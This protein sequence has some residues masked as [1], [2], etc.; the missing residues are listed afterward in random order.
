MYKLYTE[1]NILIA[2]KI[3]LDRQIIVFYSLEFIAN[4]NLLQT[5][6]EIKMAG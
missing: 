1:R 6:K 4:F 5:F 3:K 2:I